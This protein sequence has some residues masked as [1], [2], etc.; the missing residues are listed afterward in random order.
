MR[1]ELDVP[2]DEKASIRSVLD[3][4]KAEHNLHEYL[5]T[6]KH[7]YDELF[8]YYESLLPKDLMQQ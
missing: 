5:D 1:K 8:C 7:K 4:K 2:F 6:M 3:D